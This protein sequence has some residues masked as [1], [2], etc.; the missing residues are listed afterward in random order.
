LVRRLYEEQDYESLL[1]Q[2]LPTTHHLVE[3]A[4]ATP[5][6]IEAAR[7]LPLGARS[8]KPSENAGTFALLRHGAKT[9]CA[10]G[11]T[12]TGEVRASPERVAHEAL[13]VHVA[14]EKDTPIIAE[15]PGADGALSDLVDRWARERG[16]D[17]EQVTVVVAESLAKRSAVDERGVAPAPVP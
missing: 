15:P 16:V 5:E 8:C 11:W 7:T 6:E 3:Y 2:Y 10:I 1:E 9:H 14:A 4:R 13:L 12:A 17:S